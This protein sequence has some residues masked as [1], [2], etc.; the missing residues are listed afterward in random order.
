MV[1]N[2][3]YLFGPAPVQLL[4]LWLHHNKHSQ[5][6]N[7]KIKRSQTRHLR[8]VSFICQLSP[9]KSHHYCSHSCFTER[10]V[11]E[12]CDGSYYLSYRPELVILILS[13]VNM[14]RLD[15]ARHRRISSYKGLITKVIIKITPGINLSLFRKHLDMR[16]ASTRDLYMYIE[17]ARSMCS[18]QSFAC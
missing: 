5:H 16:S 3:R 8:E 12:T 15:H 1:P 18:A 10:I 6:H 13:Y 11:L 17:E 2:C 9:R 14:V 7:T 4:T